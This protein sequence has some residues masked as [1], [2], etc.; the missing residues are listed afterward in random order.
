MPCPS[1][2]FSVG[3][4]MMLSVPNYIVSDGRMTDDVKKKFQEN[5]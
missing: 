1:G 5:P 4:L 2:S 3:Y